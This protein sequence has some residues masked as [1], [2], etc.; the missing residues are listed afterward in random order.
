MQPWRDAFEHLVGRLE[1]PMFVVTAGDGRER[2]GCLVGFTTQCSIDPPRF[3]I[4]ISKQNHTHGIAQRATHLTM[5]VLDPGQRELAVLFGSHTGD[6]VDKLADCRWHAG[7]GDTV[8][9]DDAA[10]WFSGR[11]TEVVDGGDH[12]W[13]MVDPVDAADSGRG[14]PMSF[15]DVK[16]L[17]PG[18]P[19]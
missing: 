18:H 16:D 8:V 2:G 10:G 11:I 13:F 14:R 15:S 9:L 7:R 17:D 4:G 12:S 3:W 19:A 1:Y 5:H 6:E